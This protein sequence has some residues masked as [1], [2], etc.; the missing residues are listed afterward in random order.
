MIENNLGKFIGTA[1]TVNQNNAVGIFTLDQHYDQVSKNAW[2]YP[3]VSVDYL[4]VGGGGGGGGTVVGVPAGGGGGGGGVLFGTLDIT[5]A[6]FVTYTA[7]IGGGGS[8]GNSDVNGSNGGAST[9]SSPGFSSVIALGGGYGAAGLN[10]GNYSRAGGN[11]ASGGGGTGYTSPANSGG[12]GTAG[13]GNNGGR[14]NFGGGGG[15]GAGA[16]GTDGN[17][18]AGGGT[19][20]IGIQWP[21]NSGIYYGGGGGGGSDTYF[22]PG[23]SPAVASGGLGG[24]GSG[25]NKDVGATAGS[26]N[27]GGGGGGRGQPTAGSVPGG[28]GGSG[29]IIFRIPASVLPVSTTA[30]AIGEPIISTSG[31]YK[32]YTF[33]NNGT[34]TF[35][36]LPSNLYSWGGANGDSTWSGV[37]GQN[38]LIDRS[39][40]TQ[41]GSDANWY[42]INTEYGTALATKTD[43]TLWGWGNN[44]RG[45]LGLGDRFNYRSSPTQIGSSSD[46]NNISVGSFSVVATKTN[47]TL[48][49]WGHNGQ[50][51]LG[52][53][54]TTSRSSPVQVGASPPSGRTWSMV[55]NG[56]YSVLATQNSGTLWAWGQ[57]SFGQLGLGDTN[58]RLSPSQVGVASSWSK[59]SCGIFSSAGIKT[60]GTLWTWGYNSNGTLGDGTQEQRS[61]PVQIGTNT[62]WKDVSIGTFFTAAVKTDGTLW[63]WGRNDGGALGHNT[64][65]NR[66]S[67]VQVGTGT[68]W[69][70]VS[71][72]SETM[73]AI[74]TDG[75][76]WTWGVD[77]RGALGRNT[78]FINASSPVQVGTDTKWTTVWTGNATMLATKKS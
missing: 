60:D 44:N 16:V 19:G 61:N 51:Q 15:G 78:P 72:G 24:G 23:A 11:G 47:G 57:N 37:L 38:D 4:V 59:I 10:G 64:T 70:M 65:I 48:W 34:I 9:L 58:T 22:N 69:L 52:Q 45:Q 41:I 17:S 40:P 53:N 62:N 28:N 74:K 32:F 39:S 13:Q 56:Y 36:S 75:T 14:G 66:S 31:E 20:G 77:G 67:P 46:W 76:L 55:S 50:G 54:D 73:A 29:V 5:Y 63:T 2:P 3:I 26:P 68:N 25:G 49:T 8:A 18:T 35:N 7:V 27:T 12:T 21:P 43:G 33:K 42:N 6:S 30:A 71:T 1:P